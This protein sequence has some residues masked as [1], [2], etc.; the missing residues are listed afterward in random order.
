[1][2]LLCCRRWTELSSLMRSDGLL[3]TGVMSQHAAAAG[4]H[5]QQQQAASHVL[6]LGDIVVLGR[7]RSIRGKIRCATLLCACLPN[8]CS[9][10]VL[11]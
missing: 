5:E 3:P 11:L 10:C 2:L 1:M 8:C 6:K 4:S 7:S 9:R